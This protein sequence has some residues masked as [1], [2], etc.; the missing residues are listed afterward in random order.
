MPTRYP[1]YRS[2]ICNC[3]RPNLL[4]GGG[5]FAS[6]YSLN[7]VLCNPS[8]SHSGGGAG[9]TIIFTKQGGTSVFKGDFATHLG[10][11]VCDVDGV[12]TVL[13]GTMTVTNKDAEGITIDIVTYDNVW[14]AKYKSMAAFQPHCDLP[15]KLVD[16][17]EV[18]APELVNNWNPYPTL[19]PIGAEA[20][21][22]PDGLNHRWAYTLQITD[23]DDSVMNF[24]VAQALA[25]LG[26]LSG[27]LW[28]GSRASHA[29]PFR[30]TGATNVG[31][32]G[33]GVTVPWSGGTDW[34][35]C[36][37]SLT[38]GVF[39]GGT[40]IFS[41]RVFIYNT[42]GDYDWRSSANYVY[43]CIGGLAVVLV[44]DDPLVDP[45]LITPCWETG[46]SDS[47]ASM[48]TPSTA[49][50]PPPPVVAIPC[51]GSF[52]GTPT[53]AYTAGDLS[54]C[55][56]GGAG[57][58][59]PCAGGSTW[60]MQRVPCPLWGEGRYIYGFILVDSS[61][62]QGRCRSGSG[63]CGAIPPFYP[64]PYPLTDEQ[65]TAEGYDA[66]LD[67][68]T[69]G[70]CGCGGSNTTDGQALECPDVYEPPVTDECGGSCVYEIVGYA[71][72]NGTFGVQVSDRT[73]AITH[74][75]TPSGNEV[76]TV[77][78]NVTS[79]TCSG[80]ETCGCSSDTLYDTEA[81]FWL[82]GEFPSDDSGLG[83]AYVYDCEEVP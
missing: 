26:A 27:T 83:G 3:I 23:V 51:N 39:T 55:N 47:G 35:V 46:F 80:T 36:R 59:E 75:G 25:D 66:Y 2:E 58:G 44:G 30:V 71:S 45:G 67:Q 72:D 29:F 50:T 42:D 41:A 22:G 70:A 31:Q 32:G 33:P 76:G 60:V 52:S 73:V 18:A 64:K 4:T 14:V 6:R 28:T 43:E 62:C 11:L 9:N 79:D 78:L 37:I 56:P 49:A 21:C 15:L 53:V 38:A 16:Y 82:F 5:G 54:D 8:R 61:T 10:L 57:P 19:R 34:W 77:Y 63:R 68:A 40:G 13:Q 12:E 7:P 48:L 69:A 1:A 24:E 81:G 74:D 17:N 20:P 65:A